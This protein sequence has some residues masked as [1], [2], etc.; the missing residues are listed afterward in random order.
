VI[1]LSSKIR[2]QYIKWIT[3]LMHRLVYVYSYTSSSES[4]SGSNING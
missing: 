1:T 2:E 3:I 4:D